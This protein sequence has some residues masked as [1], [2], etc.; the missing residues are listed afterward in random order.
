MAE[1]AE[2]KRAV[3]ALSGLSRAELEALRGVI[4]T[5]LSEGYIDAGPDGYIEEKYI[6]RGDKTYGP[7][8]Y[9]RVREDGKL[10]SVYLGKGGE[11]E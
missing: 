7:Y 4:D 9:R 8:R 2:Y 3:T 5:L 1:T 6:R 11:N 10:R